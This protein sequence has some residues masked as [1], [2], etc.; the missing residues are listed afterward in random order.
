MTDLSAKPFFEKAIKIRCAITVCLKRSTQIYA[1][2]IKVLNSRVSLEKI[3][4]NNR[5]VIVVVRTYHKRCL[6][7]ICTHT[8]LHVSCMEQRVRMN[9]K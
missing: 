1:L 2:V 4:L 8:N 7:Y 5:S 9:F 6:K 3:G